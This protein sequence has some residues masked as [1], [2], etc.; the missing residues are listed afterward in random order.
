MD[1]EILFAKTSLKMDKFFLSFST[2]FLDFSL[3]CKSISQQNLF[4]RALFR[5]TLSFLNVRISALLSTERLQILHPRGVGGGGGSLMN[6]H[7]N[8]HAL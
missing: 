3:T 2:L 1:G 5:N 4:V 6:L 8:N 7:F